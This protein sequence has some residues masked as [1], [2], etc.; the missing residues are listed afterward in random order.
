MRKLYVPQ[1]RVPGAQR[2]INPETLMPMFDNKGVPLWNMPAPVKYAEHRKW[3][4]HKRTGQRV[5]EPVQVP[6]YRGTSA[7]YARWVMSQLRRQK[8]KDAEAQVEADADAENI[9]LQKAEA[10]LADLVLN[11]GGYNAEA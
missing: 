4:R 7:A 8:R 10:A 11:P 3:R 6:I 9:S 5:A 2:R 1:T